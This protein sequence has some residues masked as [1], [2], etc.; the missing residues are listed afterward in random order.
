MFYNFN[1][2]WSLKVPLGYYGSKK[3]FI[4]KTSCEEWTGSS[5]LKK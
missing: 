2:N 5:C 4:S 1:P 3:I